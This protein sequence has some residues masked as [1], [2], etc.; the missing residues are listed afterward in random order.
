[1]TWYKIDDTFYDHPKV[2]DLDLATIG[3][4]TLAGVW[5]AKH[6]SDGRITMGQLRRLGVTEEHAAALVA[7]N[8]WSSV[9]DT[10]YEF[11]DWADYQPSR[12]DVLAQRKKARSR[13][14]KLRNGDVRANNDDV[15]ANSADGSPEVRE[16]FATPGAANE[17]RTERP[18]RD[19]DP[20]RPDPSS[21]DESPESPPRKRGAAAS[22]SGTEFPTGTFKL[23][24]ELRQW[25][26]D[27]LVT[28]KGLDIASSKAAVDAETRQFADYWGSIPGAR[29]RRKDWYATWRVWMRKSSLNGQGPG[30][31]RR[32]VEPP[33]PKK[34]RVQ[35]GTNLY[36][37]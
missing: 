32:P 17:R 26:V 9:D 6:L 3:A 36:A 25:A 28:L 18:V 33:A 8:L 30:A 5:C 24:S 7:A 13:M 34:N 31:A 12:E 15:R 2:I 10:T 16:K 20:T 29:G 11:K 19:P 35:P 21:G 37:D 4:W 22:A 27:N 23:N 14:S 1:M